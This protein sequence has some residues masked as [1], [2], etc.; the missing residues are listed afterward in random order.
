MV[1]DRTITM[2][3]NHHKP[4]RIGLFN[5]KFTLNESYMILDLRD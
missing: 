2:E 1:I 4:D 5:F 3:T